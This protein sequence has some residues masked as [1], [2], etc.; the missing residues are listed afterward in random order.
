MWA[1]DFWTTKPFTEWNEKEVQ[2]ILSDSPWTGRVTVTGGVGAGIAE[3]GGGGRGGGR[4]GGGGGGRGGPQGDA[5]SADPGIDGGGGG[6]GAGGGVSVT[7][8][9]QTALPVRQALVKRQYGAE[10]GT[11]PEA[12]AK[13]DRVDQYYVLTLGGMPGYALG[14]AQG[15]RKAALLESTTVTVYGKPPLKAVEVQV[16]GGGRG[17]GIVSFVFPKTT[18]FTVDDKE[19]EFASKFGVTSVK[20]KFKLK[21]MVF[22]GK[23]EM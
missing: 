1:A 15:D 14:A 3:A 9:W 22:N 16:T 8:I 13:L 23:V 4:G 7:L 11:S 19:M 17:P 21:D 2:K 5:A 18:T 20:R 12:K 6:L 10:A